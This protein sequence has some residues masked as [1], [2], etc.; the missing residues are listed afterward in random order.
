MWYSSFAHCFVLLLIYY[1]PKSSR[2][3]G[4]ALQAR[5]YV[6][7]DLLTALLMQTHGI[8]RDANWQI[9]TEFLEEHNTFVVRV[10]QSRTFPGLLTLKVKALFSV[11]M[12]VNINQSTR[13]H[14][15]ED[16]SPVYSTTSYRDQ[17]IMAFTLISFDN[18]HT[19]P[20]AVA[21][22]SKFY[23]CGRSTA[24][25]VG[26]NPTGGMDVCLL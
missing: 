21:A 18:L 19:E 8:S 9:F 12:P 11:E 23:F 20:I 5:Y 3:S 7:F 13:R 6:R 2:R 1:R 17:E 16:T 22:R 26:S 4:N 25:I 24:E 10:Q 14:I 15:A